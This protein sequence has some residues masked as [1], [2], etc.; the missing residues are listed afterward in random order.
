MQQA[1]VTLD[2]P[3]IFHRVQRDLRLIA[4]ELADRGESMSALQILAFEKIIA[5]D[6]RATLLA[7][8]APGSRRLAS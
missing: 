5:G 6:A 1:N 3:E 2:F 8:C 4:R 7:G